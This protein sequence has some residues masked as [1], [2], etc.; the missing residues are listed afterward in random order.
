[1]IPF[2]RPEG[3]QYLLSGWAEP[4]RDGNDTFQRAAS[5]KT[6]FFFNTSSVEPLFLH[7]KLSSSP[8]NSAEVLLNKK[9]VGSIRINGEP[10][11]Y[12]M[13]LPSDVVHANTNVV[14][15]DWNDTSARPAAY[16]AVVTPAKYLTGIPFYRLEIRQTPTAEY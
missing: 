11:V 7:M 6:S 16:F 2:G 14:E 3:K 4:E 15:L 9:P 1:M 5:N 8:A 13:R 12:S 10:D